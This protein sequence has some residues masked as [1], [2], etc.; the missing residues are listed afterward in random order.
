MNLNKYIF[1]EINIYSFIIILFIGIM[2]L[3]LFIIIIMG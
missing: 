2:N 1:I 3:Y